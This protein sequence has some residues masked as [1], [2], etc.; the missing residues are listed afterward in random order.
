[1]TAAKEKGLAVSAR[2]DGAGDLGIG[3]ELD[4]SFVPLITVPGFRVAQLAENAASS[5]DDGEDDGAEGGS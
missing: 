4:G 5:S 3:V 2:Y 1:M